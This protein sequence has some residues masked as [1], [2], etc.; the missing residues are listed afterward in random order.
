MGIVSKIYNGPSDWIVEK[1]SARS[2]R[3]FGFWT[4]ILAIIGALFF[5][6][7][8]FYVTLLSLLALIP[9]VTAETPVEHE[10]EDEKEPSYPTDS[11][12]EPGV[13][14]KLQELEDDR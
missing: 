11:Q 2:R 13:V 5:G 10:D 4:L 6:R 1:T 7:V 14:D 3:S 8:V 12:P 9:N